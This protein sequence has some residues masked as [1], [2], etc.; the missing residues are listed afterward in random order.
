MI[1]AH[2]SSDCEHLLDG[3]AWPPQRHN[4]NLVNHAQQCTPS[5]L[6]GRVVAA[7]FP[8]AWDEFVQSS[9]MCRIIR[10]AVSIPAMADQSSGPVMI[11]V[12]GALVTRKGGITRRARV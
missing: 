2:L 3:L 8:P 6:P 9:R 12:P 7:C 4:E 5:D 1:T 11:P 10:M